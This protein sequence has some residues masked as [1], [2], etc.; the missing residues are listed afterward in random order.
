[1]D[2][3]FQDMENQLNATAQH[4]AHLRSEIQDCTLGLTWALED[5]ETLHVFFHDLLDV[6]DT[7]LQELKKNIDQLQSFGAHLHEAQRE[8][9]HWE[10]EHKKAQSQ[11]LR[12]VRNKAPACFVLTRCRKEISR[13]R[14]T[15]PNPSQSHTKFEWEYKAWI[16]RIK[17]GEHTQHSL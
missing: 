11:N 2:E 6:N 3:F 16:F 1:M 14:E 9:Q 8:R 7:N 17:G 5:N 15:T 12:A 13:G 10:V 4:S